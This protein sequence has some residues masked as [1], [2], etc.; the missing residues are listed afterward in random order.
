VARTTGP[1]WGA[2]AALAIDMVGARAQAQRAAHAISS[3]G[4]ATARAVTK[5]PAIGG[6]GY[7]V[8]RKS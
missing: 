4:V 6:A 1:L 7:V 2:G 5:A 3:S 8:A